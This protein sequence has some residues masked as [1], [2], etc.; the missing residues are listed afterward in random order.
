[1]LLALRFTRMASYPREVAA[2]VIVRH[3]IVPLVMIP[4]GIALGLAG[5]SDGLP[6]KVLIIVSVMPVGFSTLVPPAIYGLDLD[7]ANS[8]WLASTALL[9]V[10]IPG[11]FLLL[12]YIL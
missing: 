9:A 10:I 6:L 8:A 4:V 12:P 5:I 1:M 11:L 3:L 2:V 7:L